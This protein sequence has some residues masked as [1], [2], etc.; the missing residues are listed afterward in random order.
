MGCGTSVNEAEVKEPN[1][2]YLSEHQIKELAD[3]NGRFM[4][5]H[6]VPDLKESKTEKSIILG[7]EAASL[8]KMEEEIEAVAAPATRIYLFGESANE[9][10]VIEFSTLPTPSI[11]ILLSRSNV[12]SPHKY[13]P[14][15]IILEESQELCSSYM[16]NSSSHPP[17][18]YMFATF[19]RSNTIFLCGGVNYEFEHVANEAFLYSTKEVSSPSKIRKERS[20]GN[21]L[22]GTRFERLALMKESRYSH[23]GVFMKAGKLGYIYVMGG[24]SKSD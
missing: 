11:E 19:I 8:N 22:M 5:E 15:E 18:N 1:R 2:E 24:R 14:N 12:P 3:S 20:I 16:Y 4:S 7:N 9:R 21:N 17:Y 23:M 6:K 13:Q 10:K